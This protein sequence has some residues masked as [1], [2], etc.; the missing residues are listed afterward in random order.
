MRKKA[1]AFAADAPHGE[2]RSGRGGK[3]GRD[4]NSRPARPQQ[5][6][7]DLLI[8]QIEEVGALPALV[9]SF[10]R[11]D[12]ERHARRNGGRTLLSREERGRMA[13]LE[14]QLVEMFRLQP[15]AR[16]S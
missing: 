7:P 6:D 3:R 4:E 16:E 8:D 13:L 10:S 1:Q 2:R 5:P 12:C 15:A 11:K 14:D 9:F